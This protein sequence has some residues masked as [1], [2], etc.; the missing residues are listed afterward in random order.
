VFVINE[1][2]PL[3]GQIVQAHMAACECRGGLVSWSMDLCKAEAKPDQTVTLAVS[4]LN[5]PSDQ[6][7]IVSWMAADRERRFRIEPL[8]L[9][10]EL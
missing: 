2:D 6:V 9:Y 10:V 7:L 4:G 5:A 8:T 3:S 1:I